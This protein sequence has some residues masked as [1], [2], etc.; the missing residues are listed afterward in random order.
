MAG[1]EQNAHGLAFTSDP[2]VDAVDKASLAARMASIMS[3]LRP[4]RTAGR[5]GRSTSTTCSPAGAVR[6]APQKQSP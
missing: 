4:P 6:H 2:G 3:V 1:D 5:F